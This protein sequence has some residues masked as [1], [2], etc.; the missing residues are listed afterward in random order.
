MNGKRPR[1][2]REKGPKKVKR[3][4]PQIVDL[5]KFRIPVEFIPLIT[6]ILKSE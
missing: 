2:Y 3:N 5:L 6:L 4:Q 1:F